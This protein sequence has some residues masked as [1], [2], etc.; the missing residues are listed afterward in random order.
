MRKR[1]YHDAGLKARV[2]LEALKGERTVSELATA[3]GVH[4]TMEEGTARRGCGNLQA[5]QQKSRNGGG[6]GD[7]SVGA[8][9]DRRLSHRGFIG[10]CPMTKAVANDLL[11]RHDYVAQSG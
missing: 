3:Y 5:G 1:R 6:Q 4:P 7:G 11:L 9:Q 8:C 10:S 2:A